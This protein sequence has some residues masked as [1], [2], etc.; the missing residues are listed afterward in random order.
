MTETF[1]PIFWRANLPSPKRPV[2]NTDEP[3]S[4]HTQDKNMWDLNSTPGR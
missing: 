4:T 1:F 2:C 3:Q